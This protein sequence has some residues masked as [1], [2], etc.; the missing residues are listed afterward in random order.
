[1]PYLYSLAGGVTQDG[2]TFL[3]PLVMDFRA[4]TNVLELADQFLCGPSLLVNPVTVFKARSRPVYLPAAAGWYDF[5]TGAWLAGGQTIEAPAPYDA[6]PLYVK[7]GTILPTGPELQYTAEKPPDPIT[8]RIY[9][10]A[11]ASF[12]LYEDDGLS[13]GYEK[14]AFA[15]IPLHWDDAN[16]TLTLGKR[17]GSFNGM[18]KDRTFNIVLITKTKPVAYAFEPVVEQVV[19]YRGAAFV[20]RLD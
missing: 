10:G 5:W 19:R 4:D 6:L 15:R 9:G 12:T 3:R 11:D 1:L 20:M 2:G 14:G 18:L 7:A 17:E 8:L 16:R 13:Y